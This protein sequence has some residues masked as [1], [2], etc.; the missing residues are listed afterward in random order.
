MGRGNSCVLGEH[1]D[2]FYVDYDYINYYCNKELPDEE[3]RIG[4]E[5]SIKEINEGW[6]IDTDLSSIKYE[7]FKYSLTE[8]MK[9]LIPSLDEENN[10]YNGD[11][12]ILLK[13]DLFMI[14][15]EDNEWSVAVK[16]LQTEADSWYLDLS[17]I[18]KEYLPYYRYCLMS[19]LFEMY[20]TL[21]IYGGA[22][23]SGTIKQCETNF[24]PSLS[25]CKDFW[26]IA[27]LPEST[28]MSWEKEIE[29]YENSN[30]EN[31]PEHTSIICWYE[32]TITTKQFLEDLGYK[33]FEE[34]LEIEKAA[35]SE[36]LKDL[37]TAGEKVSTNIGFWNTESKSED[38]TQFDIET[39]DE[40][41]ELWVDFCKVE[42]LEE[43]AVLYLEC[44]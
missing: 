29:A 20:N 3:P 26:M 12:K 34:G 13:D 10:V 37:L 22:W 30:S 35:E 28:L 33:M 7:E 8:K 23:T 40:L 11:C 17:P 19:A 9:E 15:L 41:K 38:E 25:K 6:E 21:G 16:I 31:E 32:R 18:Q 27:G 36:N 39:V 14:G 42:G 1:E 43:N 5:I 4:A 44:L 2:L 24:F